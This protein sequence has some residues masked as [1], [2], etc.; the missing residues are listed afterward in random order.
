MHEGADRKREISVVEAGEDVAEIGRQS[1]GQ[2]GCEAEDPPFPAGA[3]QGAGVEG[4]GGGCPVDCGVR[5]P[6]A[7][8]V[9]LACG[10][11]PGEVAAAQECV[12]ADEQF[13][14]GL[15]RV[16]AAGAGTQGFREP[17]LS[18]AR[19]SA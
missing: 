15:V 8:L 16:D 14:G 18:V 5:G 11:V 19:L 2:A 10:D 13:D 1:G 4:G 9:L 17:M 3:G 12:V 7:A 6:V